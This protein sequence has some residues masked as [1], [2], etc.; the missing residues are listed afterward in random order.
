MDTIVV[1][2]IEDNPGDAG[3]VRARLAEA[4][5]VR[6]TLRHESRLAAGLARLQTERADVVLLDL[7]LP[8]SHGLD[9]V[10]QFKL[11]QPEL[12]IVV[13]SGSTDEDLALAAL[14]AGAQDYLMKGESDSRLVQR[15]IRYAIE[16]KRL[17]L[18][19]A[20]VAQYDSLTGLPN[21]AL[22]RDRLRRAL[23]R[24]KR[25]RLGVALL[26]IDLDRFKE[27]NDTL[28]HHAGDALLIEVAQRLQLAVRETD[29]VARLG[30]DEF[31]V[32]IESEH[33]DAPVD[34]VANK[35]L[36]ALGREYAAVNGAIAV[37]PSIGAAVSRGG[38]IDMDTL[39]KR[40]DAAMYRAKRDG[41]NRVCVDRAAAPHTAGGGG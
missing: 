35:L 37:T 10:V 29:T 39:L 1:L 4:R 36:H 8:D 25:Q 19:L 2:L 5:N 20:R 28:G 12:P 27:V 31:V 22:F 23:A 30:G 11:A 26:F 32:L 6:F 33:S 21:R 3:L 14:K 15:A 34:E 13:L 41:R 24:A 16:R 18:E 38:E 9:T 17:E 40:A 7:S